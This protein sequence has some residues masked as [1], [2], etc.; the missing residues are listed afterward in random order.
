MHQ[1]KDRNQLSKSKRSRIGCSALGV[2]DGDLNFYTGFDGDRRD[3]LDDLG[4]RVKIDHALVNSHL[5]PEKRK[6]N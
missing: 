3:L 4:W 6:G 1:D 2:G 5:K